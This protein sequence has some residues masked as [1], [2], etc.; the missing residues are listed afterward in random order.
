ML[1]A[2]NM[3]EHF[4]SGQ[5]ATTFS[6]DQKEASKLLISKTKHAYVA[7]R[8][9]IET[10]LARIWAQILGYERVGIE[11]HFQ[12]LGGTSLHATRIFSR[13][14]DD[15][16]FNLSRSLILQFPT[17]AQMA[18]YIENQQVSGFNVVTTASRQGRLEDDH[19]SFS[20]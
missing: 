4:V 3:T 2:I 6:F 10:E 20:R 13:L 12:D 8:T 9:P 7:P 1:I 5:N 15:L 16:G 11:D 14:R 19:S 17:I 18:V